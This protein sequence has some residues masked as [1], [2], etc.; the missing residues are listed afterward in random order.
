VAS[1]SVPVWVAMGRKEGRKPK[2][3]E[4]QEVISDVDDDGSGTI[5][6]EEFLK[7]VIHTPNS[8]PKDEIL[9]VMRALGFEP[10][11]EEMQSMISDVYDDGNGN[12]GY[13]FFLELI[14]TMR[15]LGFVPRRK[16]SRKVFLMSMTM[17][18]APLVTRSS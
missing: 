16:R 15:A 14:V 3:E 12:I 11:K 7:M 8:H 2:K 9:K 4:I 18:V 10:K 5:G 6:Y 1:P 13:E 17:A